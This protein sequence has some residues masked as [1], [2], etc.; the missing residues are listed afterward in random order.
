[1][2]SISVKSWFNSTVPIDIFYASCDEV[3][4]PIPVFL[5]MEIQNNEQLTNNRK[6]IWFVDDDVHLVEAYV[7]ILKEEGYEA[8]AVDNVQT[9]VHALRSAK[10]PDLILVDCR[11][12][13]M[14]GEEFIKTLHD[15]IPDLRPRSKVCA[16]SALIDDPILARALAPWVDGFYEKPADLFELIDLVKNI[17]A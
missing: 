15:G 8:A 17:L 13:G 12:P 4:E 3:I 6:S 10:R 14:D 7:E 1:M 16:F 11:M 5:D 9:A 2:G